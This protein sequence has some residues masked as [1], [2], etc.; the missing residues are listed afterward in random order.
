MQCFV[1]GHSRG[2]FMAK[3]ILTVDQTPYWTFLQARYG[4]I[5]L[6]TV[7]KKFCVYK[8]EQYNAETAGGRNTSFDFTGG[9]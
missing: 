7:G 1:I 6:W 2:T 5:V 9:C 4:Q 8:R 3:A